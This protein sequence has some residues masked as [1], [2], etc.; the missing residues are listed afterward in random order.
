MC[1]CEGVRCCRELLESAPELACFSVCAESFDAL[2]L[3]SESVFRVPEHRFKKLCATV[4]AQ[5]IITVA[6]K[7][8]PLPDKLINEAPFIVILDRVGDPGNFGTICRTMK[9]AGLAELWYT[10]GTVDPF[11]DKAIR[12]GMASQFSLRLREFENF[13]DIAGKLSEY[14]FGPLYRADPSKGKNCF[15]EAGLFNKTA[16]VL[17][18]EGSGAVEIPGSLPLNIPMPGDYES[19][20]VAQAASIILFEY[21]RRLDSQRK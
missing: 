4:N 19:I 6:A 12:S 5:G 8:A 10:K 2:R 16:L 15:R 1:V 18:S 14:G 7:P 13:E 9:A 21:V 17:G 11:G 20:N 3:N